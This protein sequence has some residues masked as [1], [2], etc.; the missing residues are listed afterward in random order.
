MK[1]IY[2]DIFNQA[3][4]VPSGVVIKPP[5]GSPS[6]SEL[7]DS[8]FSLGLV[9]AGFD[10]GSGTGAPFRHSWGHFLWLARSNVFPKAVPRAV[11]HGLGELVSLDLDSGKVSLSSSP[12]LP[13]ARYA[14]TRPPAARVAC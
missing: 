11:Q 4:R 6:L 5:S 14:A 12:R 2:N 10:A 3:T 9:S 7:A 13:A 1:Q 8:A